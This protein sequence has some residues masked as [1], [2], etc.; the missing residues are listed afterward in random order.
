MRCSSGSLH[1]RNGPRPGGKNIGSHAG[2]SL[3]TLNE[4]GSRN[5]L[6]LDRARGLARDVQADAVDA[7]HL[8]DHP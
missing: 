2:K 4:G 6:P 8:A 1:G 7:R 5:L 3:K